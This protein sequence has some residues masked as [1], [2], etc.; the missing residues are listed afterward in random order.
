MYVRTRQGVTLS[1]DRPVQG[2]TW[3]FM[4]AES[5]EPGGLRQVPAGPTL[6]SSLLG[7]LASGDLTGFR[8]LA[9]GFGSWVR[10]LWAAGDD[11]PCVA[12]DRVHQDERGIGP[13]LW[14]PAPPSFDDPDEAIAW[15][16]L[17]FDD[18]NDDRVIGAWEK[19]STRPERIAHWVG[20]SGVA[21]PT[22]A[23]DAVAHAMSPTRDAGEP[24]PAEP[25]VTKQG[26]ADSALIAALRG[27]VRERNT[28][29][30]HREQALRRLRAA[31]LSAEE[32]RERA[33]REL[34]DVL[35]SRAYRTGARL[36]AARNP[37]ELR[38]AIADRG[39]RLNERL[40][41]VAR[42]VR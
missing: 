19:L 2:R 14:A 6:E 38:R 20:F 26:H 41:H 25:P 12:L 29:L 10:N 27:A 34:N 31:L 42:Q 3:Q 7:A 30:S 35:V 16:W 23:L 37:R 17:R 1:A 21:D 4:D 18:R 32:E 28:Q 22:S 9:S 24:L 13:A 36:E 15:A 40:A 8:Q 39:V 33:Q 11:R 5:G